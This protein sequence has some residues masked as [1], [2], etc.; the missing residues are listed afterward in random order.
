MTA[1]QTTK[2]S[3]QLN[4]NACH[5]KINSANQITAPCRSYK[6]INLIRLPQQTTKMMQWFATKKNVI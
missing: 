3:S 4:K 6:K 5:E 2:I 1:Q